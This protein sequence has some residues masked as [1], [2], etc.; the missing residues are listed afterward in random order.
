MFLSEDAFL[1]LQYFFYCPTNPFSILKTILVFYEICLLCRKVVPIKAIPAV[2]GV[3]AKLIPERQ[4]AKFS[5][6]FSTVIT[7]TTAK[8]NRFASIVGTEVETSQ[9]YI[10]KPGQRKP[11]VT[12]WIPHTVS[13]RICLICLV[14]FEWTYP[15]NLFYR[16]LWIWNIS[17]TCKNR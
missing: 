1:F 4:V 15:L 13:G 12:V 10:S 9:T 17:S 3:S 16:H 6:F 2:H 11:R 5:L 8:T 14:L 7:T